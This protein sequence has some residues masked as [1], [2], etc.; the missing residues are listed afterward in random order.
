MFTA[1]HPHLKP[2][3]PILLNSWSTNLSDWLKQFSGNK[4]NGE[5][6]IMV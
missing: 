1:I 3:P 4:Q 5:K 6:N 2:S